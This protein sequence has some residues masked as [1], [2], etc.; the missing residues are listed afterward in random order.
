MR[1]VMRVSTLI[2]CAA[3]AGCVKTPLGVPFDPAALKQDRRLLARCHWKAPYALPKPDTIVACI[4]Q[5]RE[6]QEWLA[7]T[8]RDHTYHRCLI[9][10]SDRFGVDA[11]NARRC[12]EATRALE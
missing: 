8:E 1:I 4:E 9:E 10:T 7:T 3:L 2:L 6:A 12:I 11:W 5:T